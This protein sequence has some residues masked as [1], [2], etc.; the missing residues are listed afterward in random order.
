LAYALNQDV[1]VCLSLFVFYSHAITDFQYTVTRAEAHE[2]YAMTSQ[3]IPDNTT[4]YI[5][6]DE[7]NKTFFEP[8]KQHYDVV[9]LDDFMDAIEGVNSNYFG[10]L[11]VLVVLLIFAPIFKGLTLLHRNDRSAGIESRKNFLWMLVQY[12]YRCVLPVVCNCGLLPAS[13][14]EFSTRSLLSVSLTGYI[15]R[16]RGYHADD[17]QTPGYQDG[18]IPSYYY[19]LKDRFLHMQEFYPVKKSFYAREFPTSWRLI[20][21]GLDD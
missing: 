18:I 13:H 14:P 5:A 19:A 12:F 17:H 16:L 9:F 1:L 10:K 15:N 6:T 3:K 21:T 7:R 8:L 2:I 11:V 20:D 4:L